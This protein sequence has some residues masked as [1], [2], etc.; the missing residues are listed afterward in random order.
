[1]K[2]APL[3]W[4]HVLLD[5]YAALHGPLT[6]AEREQWLSAAAAAPETARAGLASLNQRAFSAGHAALCLS[7]GGVRSASFSLGVL[8][9]LARLGVLRRFDY[10]STVSG[11]GFAG[12]WLTAWLRRAQDDPSAREQLNQFEGTAPT[13]GVVEPAPLVQLRK[14]IRY[15]SPHEGVFSADVWTLGATMARNLIVNW[16]VLLPVIA[17]ALL[18]PRLHFSLIHLADRNYTPGV[19]FGSNEPETWILVVVGAL[20]AS[21]FAYTASDLPSYGNARRPQRAFIKWCLVPLTV[22]T[23]A[24]TYFWA[25]DRVPLTLPA[26][27]LACCGGHLVMWT[28]AGLLLGH[29]SFRPRTSVA[30]AVSAIVPAVGLWWMMQVLYPNGVELQAFYVATAFPMAL[31]FLLLGGFLFVGIAGSEFD[32]AD[33]EWWSRFAGW[34]LIAATSWL[35]ASAIVFGGPQLFVSVRD[36]VGQLLNVGGPHASIVT[37]L[38]TPV[39]GGL[40]A[41]LSRPNLDRGKRSFARKLMLAL[42]APAFVATLMATVSWADEQLVYRLA[43]TG[44]VSASALTAAEAA[45]ASVFVLGAALALAGFFTSRL[46]PVNKFSLSGMYRQRLVR[47]FVGAS[48][49]LRSPN[50]FTGFDPADDLPLHELASVR[51]LHVVNATLNMVGERQLGRQERKA[52]PFTFSPLHAGA[53]ALGYRPVDR[54]GADP[55]TGEGVSLGTAITISGAAASPSMGMFSTPATTFLMTLLNARLGTWVGNPGA[56]GDET[57]QKSEP[58]RGARLMIDEL[59][60]RTT[61]TRPYVYLSD[62]G[63]FDNLGLMEMVRRRCRFVLVVDGGA[64]PDYAFTD[65]ANAVRRIRIDLGIRIE[66]D[67]I[68]M[69]LA[70]QGDGNPH[71]LTGTIH[72][73]GVDGHGAVGTLIY[74][75]P[76]LSGDEP[77]DVRNYAGAHPLFPHESTLNQWFTEAQFESYRMLGMHTVEAISGGGLTGCGKAMPLGG[78]DFWAA[79]KAYRQTFTTGAPSVAETTRT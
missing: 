38:L 59:L 36:A 46:I 15:M 31:V 79:A 18:I 60:G 72:Y 23:L 56:A 77:S 19:R 51:P 2:A 17:A 55:V 68:D 66:M 11:G 12:A 3:S 43:A 63:H 29:R 22:G 44:L 74:I 73:D 65:L 75:K 76:C 6:A 70:R 64:D 27:L 48:R 13:V 14:Y 71:C 26:V 39:L 45:L 32:T 1:M 61:A 7:G 53:A 47:A 49:S 40:A 28:A 4:I 5:E 35:V 37:A 25:V 62:G 34:G 41:S 30:G 8:Q 21:V 50:P 69:S 33:L 52:E 16:L 9:G 67:R 24:L 54:Y 57:W 10:L 42:A 78:A 58:A 20:M